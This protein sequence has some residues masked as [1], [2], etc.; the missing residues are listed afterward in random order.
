MKIWMWGF[1]LS[2]ALPAVA[3]AQV[4]PQPPPPL[5]RD[6]PG[7]PIV[8]GH[9]NPP[10]PVPEAMPM[11]PTHPEEA[12]SGTGRPAGLAF[13]IGIG[14]VFPTSLQTP[15]T[16]SVRVRLPSGLTLEPQLVLAKA[17]TDID[18]IT[19]MTNKQSELTLGSLVRYPLR[20][21]TKVD[22]EI[23]GRASISRQTVDPDGD[24]NSRTITTLGLDYGGA[25]A[26]WITPHWNLS[27]TATNPL[28]SYVRTRQEM[29]VNPVTTNKSTTIGLVFDPQ[30]VLMVHLYD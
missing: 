2:L 18:N 21:H 26:Y 7:P 13:G 20:S 25:I 24:D 14:Y 15:N 1:A 19:T 11:M 3:T 23:I 10:P 22:L 30:V 16:T 9:D 17:S 4:P 8:I 12:P 28:V 27:L 5:A 6:Q 29:G